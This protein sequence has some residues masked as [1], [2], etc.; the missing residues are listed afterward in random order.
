VANACCLLEFKAG[1]GVCVMTQ[2]WMS[3]DKQSLAGVVG[4]C[5]I[6]CVEDGNEGSEK[7]KEL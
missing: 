7:L 4:H 3:Q 6:D 1:H 5:G 2:E